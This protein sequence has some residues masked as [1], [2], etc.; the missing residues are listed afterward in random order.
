[1]KNLPSCLVLLGWLL[2]G[3]TAGA[4]AAGVF[5]AVGGTP[6]LTPLDEPV[7]RRWRELGLEPARPCSDAVFLRRAHLDAIGTLPTAAEARAFLGDRSPNKRQVLVDRLLDR[8]EFA[9]YWTMKWSELLRVK[10]EYPVNLWPNAAQ[11]YHRWIQT[12]LR[13]NRPYDRFARELLTASG[14]NFRVAPVN[15][16][17]AVQSREPVGLAQAVALTFLGSRLETWPADRRDG[18]AA[19]FSRVGYKS[20]LEWKEEIVH[21]TPPRP[22]PAAGVRRLVARARQ[23]VVCPGLGEPRLVLVAGA[24]HCS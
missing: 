16:Y 14:S 10:S 8:P 23:P 9:D 12:A 7:V 18:L 4:A 1:M 24:R 13:E 3:S 17:R 20:T 19:V 5:E 6:P 22:R 2:S 11:A 15:F 21:R